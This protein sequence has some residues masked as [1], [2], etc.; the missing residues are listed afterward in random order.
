MRIRPKIFHML[1]YAQIT[2]IFAPRLAA[3]RR[4]SGRRFSS[5]DVA[6]YGRRHFGFGG[7][8]ADAPPAAA[9]TARRSADFS[10]RRRH[11]GRFSPPFAKQ[12]AFR[13]LGIRQRR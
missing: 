12:L 6:G 9:G 4:R 10:A 13:A 1:A 8:L 5:R 7:A 2:I 3:G 11:A